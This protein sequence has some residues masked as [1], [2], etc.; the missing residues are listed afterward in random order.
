MKEC[1]VSSAT[2][3]FFGRSAWGAGFSFLWSTQSIETQSWVHY[4]F[5]KF[6]CRFLFEEEQLKTDCL[7]II[8]RTYYIFYDF[9]WISTISWIG[10][11]GSITTF[12]KF[13]RLLTFCLRWW[14]GTWKTSA[15]S[16]WVSVDTFTVSFLISRLNGSGCSL[17]TDWAIGLNVSN[18]RW[19]MP[20]LMR[21]FSTWWHLYDAGC[22]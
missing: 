14:R 7:S 10:V 5:M 22:L 1:V 19:S 16:E 11:F 21:N 3:S 6:C 18:V 15:A 12:L 9:A 13:P 20:R 4:S 8:Q 17:S 2:V